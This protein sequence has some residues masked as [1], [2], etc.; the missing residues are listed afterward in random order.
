MKNEILIRYKHHSEVKDSNFGT[1]LKE[2]FSVQSKPIFIPAASNGGEF[3]LQVFANFD[4]LDFIAGALISKWTSEIVE[5]KAKKYFVKPLLEAIEKLIAENKGSA[6]LD[7]RRIEIEFDDVTIR[8]L[9]IR[10]LHISKLS[11]IFKTLVKAVPKIEQEKLGK[12][13]DI[14]IPMVKTNDD[15]RPFR[16]VDEF[17]EDLPEAKDYLKYWLLEFNNGV[18]H[19]IYDIDEDK[20]FPR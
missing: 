6:P 16:L 12:L 10:S 15:Y 5:A 17:D 4:F 8:I 2:S 18:E 20:I 14:V 3:W 13:S 9:G 19:Y 1:S 7:M 11:G